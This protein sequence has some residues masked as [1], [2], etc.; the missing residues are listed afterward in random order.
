MPLTAPPVSIAGAADVAVASVCSNAVAAVA[1][2]SPAPTVA[3]LV[4]ED[5]DDAMPPEN[6]AAQSDRCCASLSF[7]CASS[8]PM[9]SAGDEIDATRLRTEL[10]RRTASHGNS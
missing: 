6:V 4:A 9:R 2:A 3:V 5:K 10:S 8:A 7:G 1:A